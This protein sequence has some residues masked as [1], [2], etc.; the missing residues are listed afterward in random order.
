MVDKENE[1]VW[2]NVGTAHYNSYLGF[3]KEKQIGVVVLSNL[4]PDYK[5]PATVM[6]IKILTDLQK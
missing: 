1:T 2:H 6:G 5:I 3:D 4:L